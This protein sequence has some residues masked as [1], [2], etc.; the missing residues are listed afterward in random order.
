MEEVRVLARAPSNIALIKYMGKA[1]V[2]QNLP[3]NPS[4][5][6]TL[7]RLCTYAEVTR[8]EARLKSSETRIQWEDSLPYSEMPA[9][10]VV[11][12]LNEMAVSKIIRHADRVIDFCENV[13]PRHGIKLKSDGNLFLRTANTFPFSSGIAS[14]ASSFAAVTFA[15]A[16][17]SA[18]NIS[19]FEKIWAEDSEFR[20]KFS[21]ISRLGSGSSCRSFEGPWVLWENDRTQRLSARMPE[22]AHFVLLVS[23]SPKKISSSQAHLL[24]KSSPLWEKRVERV[25]GR[26][27]KMKAALLG[28]D[29]HMVSQIAW[30]ETM[31]M[32]S[33]FHTCLKPFSYWEPET[34][35]I[36]QEFAPLMDSTDA[37]II[38][39]DAGPNVH[40]MVPMD[41]K[42]HWMFKLRNRFPNLTFL[43]DSEGTGVV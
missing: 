22:I 28:G 35:D 33:L 30:Q 34:I 11:P 42:A 37:P 21:Q 1:D 18:A 16:K 14:S 32:H 23:T 8:K 39:L 13:F 12:D 5:S 36:L 29:F 6:M 20:Q 26:I 4:L 17:A 2:S 31:E 40:V 38:T 41:Q 24:V 19:E 3:E 9:T 43:Q 25:L 7:N 27:E 10:A 15:V